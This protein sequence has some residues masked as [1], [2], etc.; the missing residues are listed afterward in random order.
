MPA[1]SSPSELRGDGY[2]S[3]EIN[4]SGQLQ[5]VKPEYMHIKNPSGEHRYRVDDFAA[6]YRL[7][8]NNLLQSVDGPG[9]IYPEPVPH[10]DV[11]RWWQLCNERRRNDDH[12]SFIAGMGGAQIREVKKWGI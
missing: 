3:F 11:C 10:C 12:L 6:Y 8:K 1:V 9:E 5:G 4:K 2:Q 7:I